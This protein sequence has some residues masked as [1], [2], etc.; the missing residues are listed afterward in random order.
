MK[1]NGLRRKRSRNGCFFNMNCVTHLLLHFDRNHLRYFGDAKAFT[2]IIVFILLVIISVPIR[3]LYVSLLKL[4]INLSR[5]RS[6]QQ[7]NILSTREEIF[8]SHGSYQ[9]YQ[10]LP[11]GV[12]VI[13]SHGSYQ[14]QQKL[15][16]AAE[17]FNSSRSYQ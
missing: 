17:V 6:Y 4:P 3:F 15:S 10:K 14:Q 9:Q 7:F 16:I 13:N 12:E 8:N 5:I 11:A 2:Y 1:Q